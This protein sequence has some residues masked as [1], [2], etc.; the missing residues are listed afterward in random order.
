MKIKIKT[1]NKSYR[2]DKNRPTISFM[3]VWDF[4]M[5]NQIFFSPQVKQLV[6]VAYKHSIYELPHEL[7]NNLRLRILGN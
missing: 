6:I 1:Q 7:P 2:Y 4:R 5:F 3:I